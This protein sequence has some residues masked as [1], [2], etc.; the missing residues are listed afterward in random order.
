L[1]IWQQQYGAY[2]LE[3]IGIAYEQ[4]TPEERAQKVNNVRSRLGINYKLLMG[5]AYQCPVKTQFGVS[6]Y[7]T[8]VLLDET[9]R[10]IWRSEGLE[11]RQITDLETHIRQRLGMRQETP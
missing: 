1:R 10:I 3:V 5:D 2:G 4:G 6:S 8:L 9:G 7:P 11:P